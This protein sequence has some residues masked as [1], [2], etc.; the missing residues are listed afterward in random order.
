METK[1]LLEKYPF[2][3][4]SSA[5]EKVNYY[6]IWDGTGWEKLWKKYLDKIFYLYDNVWNKNTKEKFSILETKEKYG[7]LRIYTSFVDD[8][9]LEL[10]ANLLS[11]WV[12]SKCGKISKNFRGNKIIY[13]TDEYIQYLC[14]HC[15]KKSNQ[16]FR[17]IVLSRFSYTNIEKGIRTTTIFKENNN[18]LEEEKVKFSIE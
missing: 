2:L 18:W 16:R 3:E 7:S 13:R 17:K 15:A 1:E 10:K 5:N 11:K 12:C 6:T 4:Y 14:K 9:K 8:E